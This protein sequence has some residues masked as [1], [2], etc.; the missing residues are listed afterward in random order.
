MERLIKLYIDCPTWQKA[1]KVD[2]FIVAVGKNK[3]NSVYHIAE[4]RGRVSPKNERMIRY[5]VKCYKAN[6]ITALQRGRNQELIPMTL[7]S[8]DKKNK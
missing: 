3:S 5:S 7:Y 2:D 1:I 8:R 6:L 4:V